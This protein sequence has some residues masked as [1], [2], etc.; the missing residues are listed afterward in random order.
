MY[1]L[2]RSS[3]PMIALPRYHRSAPV[4]YWLLSYFDEIP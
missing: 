1:E 2:L 4:H 3:Q